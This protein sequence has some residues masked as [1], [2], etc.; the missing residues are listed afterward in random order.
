MSCQNLEAIERLLEG[1]NRGD[2]AALNHLDADA[3]LQDQP[4]I[5]GAGWNRG[6]SGAVEWAVKLWEAFGQVVLEIREPVVMGDAVVAEWRA[7]AKGKRSGLEVG[8]RGYC[9]FTMSNAKVRR[10]EFFGDLDA[11]FEAAPPRVAPRERD[12]C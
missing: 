8:M 10:V 11:A 9:L 7:T 3:E 5:P 4:D 12:D 2:F 6:H 1:F